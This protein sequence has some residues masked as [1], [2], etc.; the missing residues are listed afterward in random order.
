MKHQKQDGS[1]CSGMCK[2]AAKYLPQSRNLE[3]ALDEVSRSP[4][5]GAHSEALLSET[6]LLCESGATPLPQTL[7]E[8]HQCC[9]HHTLPDSSWKGGKSGTPGDTR[10]GFEVVKLNVLLK[11]SDL[12]FLMFKREIISLGVIIYSMQKAP[13]IFLAYNIFLVNVRKRKRT[14]Q[15]ICS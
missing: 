4:L 2:V 14:F 11:L 6:I 10:L 1:A 7:R 9:L 8:R 3:T 13:N 12:N 15:H 5:H